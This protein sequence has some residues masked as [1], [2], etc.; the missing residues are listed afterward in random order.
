[1][2]QYCWC[3][4]N[5]VDGGGP[6]LCTVIYDV[7]KVVE[8]VVIKSRAGVTEV[9][10]MT[11]RLYFCK[12]HLFVVA[13][14]LYLTVWYAYCYINIRKASRIQALRLNSFFQL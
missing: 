2:V 3:I 6:P 11:E 10:V 12:R 1:M 7:S 14:F 5:Q 8:A 4:A 13:A 9:F